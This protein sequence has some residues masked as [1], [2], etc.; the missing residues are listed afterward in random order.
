MHLNPPEMP[1]DAA[2]SSQSPVVPSSSDPAVVYP[3]DTGPAV[4]ELQE[5]LR[6]YG[7][8]LK[9]DGDFGWR[10]EAAVRSFQRRQNLRI[11]GI[12]GLQTWAALKQ[13]LTPGCRTLH[14][15][16]TGVDVY[17]LQGLLQVCGYSL[18]RDSVFG[19]ET[20]AVV[21]QFQRQ[22]HLQ[23][24]GIVGPNTWTVLRAGRPI[25]RPETPKGWLKN[26]GKWW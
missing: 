10:T 20:E 25:H 13:Q 4:V 1:E 24:N 26:T 2:C 6:A 19:E 7:F 11:D 14:R 12:V 15:G 21:L 3:W 17:E 16:H 5:L 18:E 23:A 9:I 22:H 8:P